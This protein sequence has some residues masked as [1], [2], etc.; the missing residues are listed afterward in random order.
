MAEP[1]L[2]IV[3]LVMLSW[4]LILKSDLAQLRED[5]QKLCD[6]LDM[7]RRELTKGVKASGGM[8][9]VTLTPEV[10][11]AGKQGPGGGTSS[12]G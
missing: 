2:C 11:A 3:S 12:G 5:N 4:I 9:A 8:R 1:I 10:A 6:K 7:L